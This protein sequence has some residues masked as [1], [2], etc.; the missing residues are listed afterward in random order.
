MRD[1]IFDIPF[2]NLTREEILRTTGDAL[3]G[4]RRL[5]I[6][7][8]N[9]AKLVD[10]RNS[11]VLMRA[12]T[13]SELVH[14]DGAG[15][16]FA[17]KVLGA[18]SQRNY[19]GIDLMCDIMEQASANETGVFLLGASQEIVESTARWAVARYPGLIVSGYHHGYFSPEEESQIVEEINQSGASILFVGMSSPKKELFVEKHWSSL[20]VKIAMGVGGSFDVLSGTLKRAPLWM[21]KNGL[22]WAFRLYQEPG[23]LWKRYFYTN[24]VFALI[25]LKELLKRR[26][27]SGQQG[28]N[29][30]NSP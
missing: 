18:P 26:R 27:F 28:V 24:S 25:V 30:K 19:P 10:S 1:K 15:I 9:V 22:E 2:D 8:M 4:D 16:Y 5:R 7:G 11:P 14:I 17:S 21:Q 12:L 3:A 6:E 23:R 13:S 20:S 29:A